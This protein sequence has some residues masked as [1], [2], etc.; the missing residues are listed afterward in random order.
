MHV[1]AEQL[2]WFEATL[3]SNPDVPI[4]VFTHAPPMGSGLKVTLGIYTVRVLAIRTYGA[5]CAM[6]ADR[7]ANICE[8]HDVTWSRL[9]GSG[10][11]HV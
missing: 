9:A 4:V 2:R 5:P 6:P 10:G 1:D 8:M 7:D 3:A 11:V